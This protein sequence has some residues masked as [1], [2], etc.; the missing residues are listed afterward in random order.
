MNLSTD[1][2][3]CKAALDILSEC[4]K[5]DKRKSIHFSVFAKCCISYHKEYGGNEYLSMALGFIKEGLD[6]KN[7]SLSKNNKL[8]L[9][10]LQK[11]L[12]GYLEAT[13]E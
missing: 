5:S 4:C 6:D 12:D 8:E 10:K 2:E 1:Q 13:P 7:I 9:R 11:E 3:L